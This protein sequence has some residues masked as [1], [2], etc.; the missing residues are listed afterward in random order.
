MIL[1][2]AVRAAIFDMDGT[3]GY[4]EGREAGAET[5]LRGSLLLRP[6]IVWRSRLPAG[7]PPPRPRAR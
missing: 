2:N 3:R 1:P 7:V 5:F 6:N 4:G